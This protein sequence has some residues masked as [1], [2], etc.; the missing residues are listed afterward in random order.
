MTSPSLKMIFT[1]ESQLRAV[2]DSHCT[3]FSGLT[4]YLELITDNRLSEEVHCF[5]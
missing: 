2:P 5:P 1:K 3:I 4:K